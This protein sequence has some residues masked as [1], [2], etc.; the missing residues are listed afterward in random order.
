MSDQ[1]Q[2]EANGR[3]VRRCC[4]ARLGRVHLGPPTNLGSPSNCLGLSAAAAASVLTATSTSGP[5][6]RSFP[7]RDL[8]FNN[9][10]FSVVIERFSVRPTERL[11]QPFAVLFPSLDPHLAKRLLPKSTFLSKKK[12]FEFQLP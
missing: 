3:G 12:S 1:Q 9:F 11:L 5:F 2:N 6:T 7:I 10:P 8:Y 4:K